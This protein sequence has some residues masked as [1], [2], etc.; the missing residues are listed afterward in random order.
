MSSGSALLREGTGANVTGRFLVRRDE[1]QRW[2]MPWQ[3]RPCLS[4]AVSLRVVL[5][6]ETLPYRALGRL[7]RSAAHADSLMSSR[8]AERCLNLG[9]ARAALDGMRAV[10]VT[11]PVR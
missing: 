6:E 8:V 7:S 5:I 11:Q 3:S 9:Q 1:D 10:S 4:I 2:R